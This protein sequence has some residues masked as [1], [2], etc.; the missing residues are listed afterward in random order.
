MRTALLTNLHGAADLA[1][2]MP[3]AEAR[4]CVSLAEPEPETMLKLA[5]G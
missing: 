5:A 2:N 3:E 4:G 1:L